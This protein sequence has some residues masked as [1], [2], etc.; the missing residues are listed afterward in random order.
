[1]VRSFTHSVEDH[2]GVLG[3]EL[4]AVGEVLGAQVRSAEPEGVVDT[5]DFL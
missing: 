5:F 2:D 4:A 1:M 3:N